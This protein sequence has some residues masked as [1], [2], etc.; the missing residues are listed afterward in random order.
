MLYEVI[1]NL[2][3]LVERAGLYETE[4]LTAMLPPSEIVLSIHPLQGVSAR[5]Q[6]KA[7]V[8]KLYTEGARTWCVADAGELVVT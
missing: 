8:V 4:S 1:T 5:N 6:I 7:T 3:F 2:R